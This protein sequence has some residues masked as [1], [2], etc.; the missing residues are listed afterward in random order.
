MGNVTIIPMLEKHRID[1]V[2]KSAIVIRVYFKR[3]VVH[4]EVINFKIIPAH[5]S[6]D[7][8]EVIKTSPNSSH[9]NSLIRKKIVELEQQFLENELLG[10]VLTKNKVIRIVKGQDM[11]KDFLKYC[12]ERIIERCP[13]ETQKETRRS[14][15]GEV[16]KLQ[17]FQK[18]VAFADIDAHFLS[19]YK[20]WMINHRKNS[21]NTIWKAFKFINTFIND[22]MTAGFI[23][24]NPFK[25]YHRGKYVQ[26]KRDF[27]EI[28][29]CDKI[30]KLLL[31]DIPERLHLIGCYYLFMCYTGFRFQDATKFFNYQTHVINEERIV[32]ETQKS[33]AQVNLLIH[34]RLRQ[35]LNFIKDHPLNI[36]NKEF[37]CYTK[38]LATMAKIDIAMTAHTGRHTFGA[39]LAELD[40]PIEKAQRLLGHKDKKSTEIY[41]HIKNKSLDQEMLKWNGI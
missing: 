40:V 35:V 38:V 12:N 11:G 4:R 41:Y 16:T 8:R 2:G 25:D 36:S 30:H 14:Y 7:K 27:L 26:G 9:L 10:N 15:F 24:D 18:N 21:D 19:R 3:T 39:T 20:A 34:D 28:S 22:A 13:K 5:W 1:K 37:N 31:E 6:E 32:I 29:D 23:K 17:E 33:G